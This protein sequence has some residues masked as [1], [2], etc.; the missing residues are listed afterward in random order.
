[1][2]F[3]A[4]SVAMDDGLRRLVGSPDQMVSVER[5]V[6]DEGP[7]RGAPVLVVRN[8]SGFSFEVLLDRAM[9]IGWADAAGAPLAWRSPRGPI[10]SSHYEPVGDGWAR[11]FGGGLLTTCGLAST[12]MSSTVDGVHFGLHGRV[13]HIA[14]ENVRWALVAD[15]GSTA[16]EVTGDI[17]ETALG[18]PSLRLRRRLVASTQRPELR[19][20]DVV[21]N[22]GYAV[23]GHMYRHHLNFGYPLVQPGATVSATADPFAAR[24]GGTCAPRRLPWVLDLAHDGDTTET[25]LYCRP[26]PGR[27]ATVS[28]TGPDGLGVDVEQETD[29]WPLLVL[30]RDS[31]PGVN[32]LGVEP[33]MSRDGGRAEAL[34]D[35][36]LRW[37]APGES[38]RY[39]T[40]VRLAATA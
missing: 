8:P 16:I 18:Q 24:D 39:A 26:W 14:A 37:L 21:S 38:R 2:G 20:E 27:T 25:V 19:I 40:T 23:A 35:G 33:S 22:D 1:M 9:D 13:A 29:G 31:R 28:V 6:R 34:L 7:G 15:G 4:D 32:V 10:A 5:L 11:T 36:E 17:V 3:G 12:G 30:W